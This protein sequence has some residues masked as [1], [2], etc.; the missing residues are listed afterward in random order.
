[1]NHLIGFSSPSQGAKNYLKAETMAEANQD[2]V[3][4]F[5]F[6]EPLLLLGEVRSRGGV[7]HG[8]GVTFK[9]KHM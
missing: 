1:M 8:L 3:P 5:A 2:S 6:Q 4:R 7:Y 9:D